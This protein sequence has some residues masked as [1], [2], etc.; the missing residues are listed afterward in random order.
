M[1]LGKTKGVSYSRLA[2]LVVQQPGDVIVRR[3]HPEHT[4]HYPPTER[5]LRILPPP[6]LVHPFYYGKIFGCKSCGACFMNSARQ[7][8]RTWKVTWSSY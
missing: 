7:K 8:G 3:V 1:T 6:S 2:P 5:D 4:R